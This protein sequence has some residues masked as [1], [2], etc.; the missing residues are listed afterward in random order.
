M[1]IRYILSARFIWRKLLL[2]KLKIWEMSLIT[3]LVVTMLLCC[4][5]QNSQNELADRLVRLH[6]VANSDTDEDQAL[7]L[8]VRDAVL[9]EVEEVIDGAENRN[10]AAAAITANMDR[11]ADAAC[12]AVAADGKTYAV[13]ASLAREFFPTREYDT[14]SLPAGNYTSLRVTIGSGEGITGGASR[15]R[16]CASRRQCSIKAPPRD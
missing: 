10:D 2:M 5:A 13:R 16:R 15:F 14:F 4:V 6:V 9:A 11:I 7:K 3:A 12:A 8:K 1:H